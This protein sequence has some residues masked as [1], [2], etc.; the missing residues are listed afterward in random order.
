MIVIRFYAKRRRMVLAAL[1]IGTTLQLSACSEQASLFALR[2]A[3]SSFTLPINQFLVA[4]F[5]A[6]AEASTIILGP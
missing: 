5:N 3:F 6:V 2:T 4:F 1:T